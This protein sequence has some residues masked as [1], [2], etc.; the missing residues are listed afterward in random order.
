MLRIQN[1]VFD[2]ENNPSAMKRFCN[3]GTRWL[4]D[5]NSTILL[6]KRLATSLVDQYP[7]KIVV[8]DP[9][10]DIDDELPHHYVVLRCEL[11]LAFSCLVIEQNI[12]I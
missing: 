8:S 6:P 12:W 7:K 10:T 11:I 1:F 2:V 3:I 5:N 4:L 9:G